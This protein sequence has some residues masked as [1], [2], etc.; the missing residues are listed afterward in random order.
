MDVNVRSRAFLNL[1]SKGLLPQVELQVTEEHYTL[2]GSKAMPLTPE[3]IEFKA[4]LIGIARPHLLPRILIGR[5]RHRRHVRHV[6]HRSVGRSLRSVERLRCPAGTVNGG[7]FSNRGLAGCGGKV[8][9]TRNTTSSVSRNG[10]RS[11][12]SAGS[13]GRVRK[14]RTSLSTDSGRGNAILLRRLRRAGRPV[15]ISRTARIRKG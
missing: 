8:N 2:F 9:S 7:R 11:V 15:Q 13:L 14:N 6:N 10:V 1:R 4:S 12:A 3:V 5:N